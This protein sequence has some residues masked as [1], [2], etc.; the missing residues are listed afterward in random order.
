MH[1]LAINGQVDRQLADEA[2]RV[3]IDWRE[4]SAGVWDAFDLWTS[5]RGA[6]AAT[7]F[8][9]YRAALDREE[10]A[11]RAYADLLVRIAAGDGGER[12]HPDSGPT[13][14]TSATSDPSDGCALRA[15]AGQ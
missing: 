12:L 7:A 15:S 5:T 4:E 6:D 13:Q 14:P 1:Q 2:I 10:C 9:A 11:T 3:Y 8:A